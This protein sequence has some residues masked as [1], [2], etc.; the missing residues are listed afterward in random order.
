M[1]VFGTK[2]GEFKLKKNKSHV[3]D[4]KTLHASDVQ[5]LDLT[6]FPIVKDFEVV[7]T[8][9]TNMLSFYSAKRKEQLTTFPRH[10]ALEECDE[11]DIPLGTRTEPYIDRKE[12][13]Q[14]RIFEENDFVYIL[15]GHNKN[16]HTW[17][18]TPRN[19][20]LKQW[21]KLLKRYW[22]KNIFI[23]TTSGEFNIRSINQEA[24][25]NNGRLL[26]NI[27]NDNLHKVKLASFP[28]V[29]DFEILVG[30]KK[31]DYI[32]FY[33]ASRNEILN[34][35]WG[36]PSFAYFLSR[37]NISI[38][39]PFSDVDQGWQVIIFE[40]G[41]F[42]YVLSGGEYTNKKNIVKKWYKVK[43]EMFELECCKLLEE[44]CR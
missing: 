37:T 8:E 34:N 9:D 25:I 29:E 13:W 24:H 10:Y 21:I 38:D 4:D 40:H 31:I 1:K 26:K 12:S 27:Y 36:F 22:Q 41:E 23:G 18:K 20:Y 35:F 15:Q 11:E 14:I 5:Q 42:V 32:Y 43:K 6:S 19:A 7:V 28:I 16:I 44:N 33:S 2:S 17:Y 30:K 3:N 39:R